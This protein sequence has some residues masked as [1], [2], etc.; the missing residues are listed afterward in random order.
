MYPARQPRQMKFNL[1]A[2]PDYQPISG[3]DGTSLQ[4]HGT[5]RI[6]EI[7]MDTQS[8]SLHRSLRPV[9]ICAIIA[10][11][12]TA[13]ILFN[14][15]GPSSAPQDGRTASMVTAAAISRAG[16]IEIPSKPATV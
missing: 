4:E 1:V 13:G 8:K 10:I 6:G 14:D 9:I 16:A 2:R 5:Q 12:A 3:L 11:G 7:T 15:F